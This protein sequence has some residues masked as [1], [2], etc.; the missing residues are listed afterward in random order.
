[1]NRNKTLMQVAG[2]LAAQA[3][4]L[5]FYIPEVFKFYARYSFEALYIE[6][7]FYIVI[8]IIL[9][10]HVLVINHLVLLLNKTE[11]IDF[12]T[13]FK[14]H[15]YSFVLLFLTHIVIIDLT[16]YQLELSK[17]KISGLDYEYSFLSLVVGD[18]ATIIGLFV[19]IAIYD[20]YFYI[21]EEV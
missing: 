14:E 2:L 11:L 4:M 7:A 16:L 9:I 8:P 15:I 19:L 3:F 1:M 21:E 5:S 10:A 12:W 6:F 13:F 17:S 18:L 20:K